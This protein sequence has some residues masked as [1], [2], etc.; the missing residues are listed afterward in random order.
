[1]SEQGYPGF[2]CF[3]QETVAGEPERI[4]GPMDDEERA[5][6]ASDIKI[7]ERY[8]AENPGVEIVLPTITLAD[9]LTLHR[10]KWTTR[11]PWCAADQD[12][13]YR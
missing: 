13:E 3:S 4:R 2:N 6:Y 8:M 1:M 5:T 9:Q 7:A 11:S 12:T 10:G